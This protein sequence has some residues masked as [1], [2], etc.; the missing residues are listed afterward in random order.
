MSNFAL[1][2]IDIEIRKKLL[3]K[4]KS[5]SRKSTG[6]TTAGTTVTDPEMVQFFNRTT[7]AHLISLSVIES[8]TDAK[9]RLAIIGAGELNQEPGDV[10]GVANQPLMRSSFEDIYRPFKDGSTTTNTLL[11]P[12]SGIKSVSTKYEGTLRSRRDAT[13]QF[14]IFSLED[15]DR[16]SPHF[17]RVGGEVL[18]EFGWN[19]DKEG[20]AY[21]FSNTLGSQ[22]ITA[23]QNNGISAI[24]DISSIDQLKTNSAENY[25]RAVLDLKGDYEYVLGTIKNFDYSLRSDGG[26][27][28]T[29]VIT[30]IG[31]SLLDN[32]VNREE[33]PSQ[34]LQ[35]ELNVEDEKATDV[36]HTNFY[37]VIDNLPEILT[38]SI[39][40]NYVTY[41]PEKMQEKILKNLKYKGTKQLE[42]DVDLEKSED[43]FS[44][45]YSKNLKGMG[46]PLDEV[47][48]GFKTSAQTLNLPDWLEFKDDKTS[49]KY[50]YNYYTNQI[51]V[52]S[53]ILKEELETPKYV[54]PFIVTRQSDIEKMLGF[55]DG[56]QY[57]PEG[58]ESSDGYGNPT[59]TYRGIYYFLNS[60][61][62]FDAELE[63]YFEDVESK[64]EGLAPGIKKYGGIIGVLKYSGN[65]KEEIFKE[66][67]Y[68][69]VPS[70]QY[71]T[72]VTPGSEIG[73][74]DY[75]PIDF[76]RAAGTLVKMRT[77][78]IPGYQFTSMTDVNPNYVTSADPIDLSL[79]PSPEP[80][81]GYH[82]NPA[83][84]GYSNVFQDIY[85]RALEYE[86]IVN[87][88]DDQDEEVSKFAVPTT[89][90]DIDRRDINEEDDEVKEPTKIAE[91]IFVAY[92]QGSTIQALTGFIW[93]PNTDFIEPAKK[94]C[95]KMFTGKKLDPLGKEIMGQGFFDA[96][97]TTKSTTWYGASTEETTQSWGKDRE[98]KKNGEFDPL[99][100]LEGFM[101]GTLPKTWVRW[102]WF[103][104]NI[105]TKYLGFESLDTEP[106]E[107]TPSPIGKPVSVFKSVEPKVERPSGKIIPNEYESNKI[108]LPSNLKTTNVNE[109]IIPDRCKTLDL[110]SKVPSLTVGQKYN[111]QLY[112][113]LGTILVDGIGNATVAPVEVRE[114]EKEG[115]DST[116]ETKMGYIRNL[117]VEVTVLR[118]AFLNI[119]S[120]R[121]GMDNFFNILRNNF[122]PVHDFEMQ[123][124]RDEGMVGIVDNNLLYDLGL[125]KKPE[126]NINDINDIATKMQVYEFPAW[127]KESIVKSQDLKVTIPDSM[128][129]TALYAGNEH[130]ANK[131]NI[132]K[133]IGSLKV[134]KLAKFLK[135]DET[136]EDPRDASLS[137]GNKLNLRPLFESKNLVS[138]GNGVDE[139]GMI[140]YEYSGDFYK[141]L[142]NV[143]KSILASTGVD[144]PSI[145]A[146]EVTETATG[147]TRKSK[148]VWDINPGIT[149]YNPSGEL[150]NPLSIPGIRRSMNYRKRMEY[151]LEFDPRT[152]VSQN[153]NAL[154]GL[155]SLG[156]TID[157]T[158][159][160]FP[161][162]SYITKYLPKAFEKRTEG[163]AIGQYPLL[164]Q[165]TNIEHEITPS[166]WNTTIN[167]MPRL[168]NKAFPTYLEKR[169]RGGDDERNKP[170]KAESLITDGLSRFFNFFN[171]NNDFAVSS[172]KNMLGI[173]TVPLIEDVGVIGSLNKKLLTDHE[174]LIEKVEWGPDS[175]LKFT[176]TPVGKN[177]GYANYMQLYNSLS[178]N[179]KDDPK[180][181][182]DDSVIRG[183][184]G[185]YERANFGRNSNLHG[186][187]EMVLNPMQML[188]FLQISSVITGVTY[189]SMIGN[190]KNKFKTQLPSPNT[191][192]RV[193]YTQALS[194][195]T[196]WETNRPQS[197]YANFQMSQIAIHAN[198]GATGENIE[199]NKSIER[200]AVHKYFGLSYNYDV[201]HAPAYDS[202]SYPEGLT[203]VWSEEMWG[204]GLPKGGRG[205]TTDRLAMGFLSQ[206]IGNET[207]VTAESA[208]Q[209]NVNVISG[210]L[211]DP[212][213]GLEV[214]DGQY[215][216]GPIY[217]GMP[218]GLFS[219]AK[220]GY[221][222]FTVAFWNLMFAA[223]LKNELGIKPVNGAPN[224]AALDTKLVSLWNTSKDKIHKF[225]AIFP[226]DESEV[227]ELN[228]EAIF[229]HALE[230]QYLIKRSS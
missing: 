159:G 186:P 3:Q 149:W 38:Y 165:A 75:G 116:P 33:S 90:G 124:G 214:G 190:S 48:K 196:E 200:Q 35:H 93:D 152:Q 168:N 147:S 141:K 8:A 97:K 78:E 203:F 144:E 132:D 39:I 108:A 98:K 105:I 136:G 129:I 131:F 229:K 43:A 212:I 218:T 59:F 79:D 180:L 13:V 70:I 41:N 146:Y 88:V 121:E 119:G 189:K 99:E 137:L 52:V 213:S 44:K 150:G 197:M 34:I 113:K 65:R 14:T 104:D 63:Q 187:G 135:L 82:D 195:M 101:E 80:T 23:Y 110:L 47:I 193:F 202:V 91:T 178:E 4:Q 58:T 128:A 198:S 83:L 179:Q 224:W 96:T 123:P 161:G 174:F 157:G 118:E 94:F 89:R 53:S 223:I 228:S 17:L 109:I 199:K 170:E 64:W 111:A 84:E 95:E 69:P 205:Y 151:E 16:L 182:N 167:G 169:D 5:F 194:D 130:D 115:V 2:P 191:V 49:K 67:G 134:Q 166:G 25:E 66:I 26:F 11:K 117:L 55:V 6:G 92:I 73:I 156:L 61:N 215:L 125:F 9:Y 210:N 10:E 24:S 188:L 1:R 7:W 76:K 18:L 155:M 162:N 15:L 87:G 181:E 45:W 192:S 220:E 50:Y 158:A 62:D 112:G 46:K 133:S 160:L 120:L 107:K 31:M 60:L 40:N 19:S 56:G 51:Y 145:E 173:N 122:G 183:K 184:G 163:T 225:D 12:I 211:K 143:Y 209:Q 204:K 54:K 85:D 208:D 216:I 27:D 22:I 227:K 32:K 171:L 114:N 172:M 28:C 175:E 37:H 176:E 103:E 126:I 221:A 20:S 148:D 127:E 140:K 230:C 106:D 154:N 206:A 29:I 222:D 201:V 74:I 142:S 30:T 21:D 81:L 72:P 139:R 71:G 153:F 102:G 100:F 185:T 36:P 68:N 217:A 138:S 57:V 219:L 164:F 42:E 86:K 177:P 226:L 77:G 207:D